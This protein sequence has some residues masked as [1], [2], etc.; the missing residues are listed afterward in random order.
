MNF[1]NVNRI[2]V[3]SDTHE[4]V[5][6]EVFSIFKGCNLILHAGDIG[7]IEVIS[8]L[9]AIAPVIAVRGNCDTESWAYSF[10]LRELLSIGGSFIYLL[11]DLQYLDL[12]PQVAGIAMIVSGHTHAPIIRAVKSV[13]YLNPGSAGPR[14][15]RN[16]VGVAVI[17]VENSRL[18][19]ELIT[20]D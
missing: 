6:N 9:Q 14:R 18:I 5:R 4:L 12:D 20:I 15:F 3:I 7:K 1:E 17:R 13:I 16:P 2:G 10:K 11:H 8:K 19:P